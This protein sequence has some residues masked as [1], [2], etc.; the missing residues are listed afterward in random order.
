MNYS[1]GPA[2]FLSGSFQVPS[3]IADKYLKLATENQLKV[4]LC[5]LRNC[6]NPVSTNDLSSML[7]LPQGEVEDALVF[8]AQRGILNIEN[9]GSEKEIEKTIVKN[10]KP[11]REDVA[12]RGLE[13]PKIMMLLQAAQLKFGRNLKTNETRTLV[14]LYDDKGMSVSLILMLLEYAAGSG[15]LNLSFIEKTAASWLDSGIETISDA[16]ARIESDAKKNI[17]ANHIFKIFGIDKR[18]PSEKES[19]L[20]SLWLNE[21]ELSDSLILQAY[22]R[23]ID[24]NA[25]ISFAYI[26]KI[27]ESWH[28]KGYKSAEDV[29][30]QKPETSSGKKNDFAAYDIAAFEKMLNDE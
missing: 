22:N 17:A 30:E 12:K 8:W 19:E 1:I 13:D 7:S 24:K 2:V 4:I 5:V 11:S 10:E 16:E 28:K 27:L 14:W 21:W 15:K 26:G 6:A 20:C 18:K 3:A 29:K 23:C 9:I 25:K